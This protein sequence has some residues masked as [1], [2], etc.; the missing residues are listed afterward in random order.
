M[1][2]QR[3]VWFPHPAPAKGG[4]GT[5]QTLFEKVIVERGYSICYGYAA[6]WRRPDIYFIF[7][8][9]KKLLLLFFIKLRYGTIV[10]R[11]DGLPWQHKVVFPGTIPWVKAEIRSLIVCSIRK[12]F[13]TRLIYQSKF[14]FEYW[15]NL[16][17]LEKP[18][19]IIHNGVQVNEIAELAV[20]ND[21]HFVASGHSILELICVEGSVNGGPAYH[22]LRSLHKYKVHLYGDA[23][24]DLLKNIKHVNAYGYRKDP[25]GSLPINVKLCYVCLETN[26]ACP[27]AVIEA[28]SHGIPVVGFDTGSLRELVG[29][30]GYLVPYGACPW[31]LE[32]PDTDALK[33]A[34]A[35]IEANWDAYSERARLR[36]CTAFNVEDKVTEY[37]LFSQDE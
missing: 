17:A 12:Y 18:S 11:L 27:N 5:F 7:G 23:D 13:A 16:D 25:F 31:K 21:P 33:T 22:V 36:A 28:L 24:R 10:H 2:Q 4:V 14:V 9:T 6:M 32:L 8:G 29:D 15:E 3:L 35:I 20:N 1:A 26:P 30:A 37:L 34:V 19:V